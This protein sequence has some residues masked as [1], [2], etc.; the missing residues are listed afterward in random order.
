VSLFLLQPLG[1]LGSSSLHYLPEFLPGHCELKP[2]RFDACRRKM[3]LSY[4]TPKVLY[5]EPQGKSND[6]IAILNPVS[7]WRSLGWCDLLFF[8]RVAGGMTGGLSREQVF[9]SDFCSFRK[10]RGIS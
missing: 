10:N 4:P 9:F 5:K 7:G 6:P 3:S 1:K 2:K 8:Y